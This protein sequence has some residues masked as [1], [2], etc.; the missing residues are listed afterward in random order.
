M[1]LAIEKIVLFVIFIIVL[2]A[3]LILLGIPISVGGQ[4]NLQSKLRDCCQPYIT[5]GC[6]TILDNINCGDMTLTEL[7]NKL[8]MDFTTVRKFCNCPK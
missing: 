5:N 6:P 2:L 1:N 7:A 8:S 4:I 3:I